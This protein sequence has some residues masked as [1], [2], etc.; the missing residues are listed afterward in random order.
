MERFVLERRS[1]YTDDAKPST[2]RPFALQHHPP[3]GKTRTGPVPLRGVPISPRRTESAASRWRDP[4]GI[5]EIRARIGTRLVLLHLLDDLSNRTYP[6]RGP[7]AFRPLPQH[8]F[9][10]ARLIPLRPDP[11]TA[12]LARVD[13]R[14]PQVRC[15]GRSRRP[16]SNLATK[17]PRTV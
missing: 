17:L 3:K 5:F 1:E 7:A 16:R 13:A 4:W 11:P 6:T 8:G 2:P 14:L 15:R 10:Q 12:C 9:V